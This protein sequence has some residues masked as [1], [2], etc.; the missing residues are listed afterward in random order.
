MY[1][2]PP[3]TFNTLDARQRARL[4][5]S[6][7]KLGAVLGETPFLLEPTEV[8]MLRLL[9]IGPT[10]PASPAP[11]PSSA[12]SATSAWAKCAKASR[13]HASIFSAS[14]LSPAATQSLICLADAPA[15]STTSLASTLSASSTSSLPARPSPARAPAFPMQRSFASRPRRSRE[16][17]RPLILQVNTVPVPPSDPRAPLS[18]LSTSALSPPPSTLHPSPSMSALSSTYTTSAPAPARTPLTP[19]FRF[20]AHAVPEARRQKMAKLARQLGENV[21]P[22][23]VFAA[24]PHPAAQSP[25][26]TRAGR[27]RSMSVGHAYP[28]RPAMARSPAP[29]ASAVPVD[30]K[31]EAAS[32]E[33]HSGGR[34]RDDAWE[35]EWGREDYQAV[36]KR[37]RALRAMK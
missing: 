2:G 35:S 37:L 33:G 29:F 14:Q 10:P 9:P 36:M 26:P 13:R 4:I 11:S 5:R 24:H 19:S 18:A 1:A 31:M 27:R 3:P 16:A 6:T 28:P 7:R 21:P 23:L 22:A 17:P 30:A 20:R 32:D 8:H 12:S 25:G 15:A 34:A